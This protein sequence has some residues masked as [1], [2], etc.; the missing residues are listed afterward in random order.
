VKATYQK[1]CD[2]NDLE[3]NQTLVV[4]VNG[5]NILIG[6]IGDKFYAVENN[7]THDNRPIGEGQIHQDQIQCPHHG[8][9]FDIRTGKA[10]QIPA[11]V[12]LRTYEVKVE[13]KDVL[14]AI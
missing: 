6:K 4:E 7:C 3:E 9:R 12:D 1:V 2:V 8:A 10:L 11:V 5:E 13:N 14:V